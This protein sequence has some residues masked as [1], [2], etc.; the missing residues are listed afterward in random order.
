MTPTFIGRWQTRIALL[1]TVGALWTLLIVPL[2]PRPDGASLGAAYRLSFIAL[3]IIAVIGVVVWEPLYHLLMQFR[4]EK[5]WP[6]LFALLT[7]ANE[8]I[9]TWFVLRRYGTVHAVSFVIHFATTWVLIWL[10]IVGP[11]RI[12]L[13]RRR[14]IGGRVLGA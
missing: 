6:S 8:A 10:T 14:F 9:V 13:L 7:G 3:A 4:W 11:I 12:V 1:A 5:D 2:L